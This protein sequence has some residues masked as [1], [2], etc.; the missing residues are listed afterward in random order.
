MRVIFSRDNI[1]DESAVVITD[2]N[3][4]NILV[5]DGEAEHITIDD[6]FLSQFTY[7]DVGR[8]LNFVFTKVALGGTIV[9]HGVEIELLAEKLARGHIDIRQFNEFLFPNGLNIRNVISIEIVIDLLKSAG[10]TITGKDL[11]GHGV[12][13]VTGTKNV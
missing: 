12:L 5:D 2:I 3:T 8:V 13:I 11:L 9:V 4:A 7:E 1:Q 6:N 10:F